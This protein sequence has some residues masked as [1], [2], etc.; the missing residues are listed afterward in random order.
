MFCVNS[1]SNEQGE[2]DT[3]SVIRYGAGQTEGRPAVS[4]LTFRYI[5]PLWG[6]CEAL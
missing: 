4:C 5:P 3:T 6:C 2:C 1:L